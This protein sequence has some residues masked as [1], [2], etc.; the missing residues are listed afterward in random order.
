MTRRCVRRAELYRRLDAYC[1]DA[2]RRGEPQSPPHFATPPPLPPPVEA[3][4]EDDED[5]WS[6]IGR[7]FKQRY[8]RQ[9]RS[10]TGREPNLAISP[11]RE[12]F[13]CP[14]PEKRRRNLSD[15]DGEQSDGG[16]HS[17]ECEPNTVLCKLD[18]GDGGEDEQGDNHVSDVPS[19]RPRQKSVSIKAFAAQCSLCRKWRLFQSKKKYE[20][21]RAHITKDPF[22]CEKAHEWKPDVTCKDPSDVHEDDN[23]LWAMDQRDIAETPPGWERFIKIRSEGSTKFADV[24]LEEN[25]Q[26]VDQGVRSYQFSFKIP[27]PSRPDYVRKRT[28]TNRN[29]GALERSTKPLPEEVQ[30]IAWAAPLTDEGPSGDNN[31]LVPYNED[32]SELL[33]GLP[34]AT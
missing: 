33:L 12:G 26:Y 19:K 27:A 31:Q 28:Q 2:R 22:K 18:E 17:S 11:L 23:R 34:A 25:P 30:P 3:P 4:R 7:Y 15:K 21:I 29:D 16:R 5:I 6:N 14:P 10:L 1:E 24:Y 13:L 32:P 9:Y 8:C 20:E